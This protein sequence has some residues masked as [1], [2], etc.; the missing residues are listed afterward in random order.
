[1][2]KHSNIQNT[3]LF[4]EYL[5]LQGV[6]GIHIGNINS[7]SE[8]SRKKNLGYNIELMVLLSSIYSTEQQRGMLDCIILEKEIEM[9]NLALLRNMLM[10][11]DILSIYYRATDNDISKELSK[12]FDIEMV[13]PNFYEL[14][15]NHGVKNV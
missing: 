15:V 6:N 1:M 9:C 7:I 10:N 2:I 14:R 3:L 5:N 11:Y 13:E 12:Y 8:Y 4:K